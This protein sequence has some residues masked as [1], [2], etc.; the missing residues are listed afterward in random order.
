MTVLAEVL[1]VHISTN[2][3][4]IFTKF[5]KETLLVSGI[6]LETNLKEMRRV[7]RNEFTNTDRDTLFKV[8]MP[9][10]TIRELVDTDSVK[11]ALKERSSVVTLLVWES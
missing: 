2:K 1:L 6:I 8:T 7:K 9:S 10:C 5:N 3:F 4:S 11:F